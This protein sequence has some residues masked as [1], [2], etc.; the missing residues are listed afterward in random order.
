M[1][2]HDAKNDVMQSNTQ[3]M[4]SRKQTK[5][6][7]TIKTLELKRNECWTLQTKEANTTSKSSSIDI[8]THN[9]H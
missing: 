8:L 7:Y 2:T 3:C 4:N 6:R 1:L 9:K 5:T